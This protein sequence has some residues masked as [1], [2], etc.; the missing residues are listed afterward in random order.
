MRLYVQN[1]TGFGD[2]S[3]R[4]QLRV[5]DVAHEFLDHTDE[6]TWTVLS[7]PPVYCVFEPGDE[8]VPASSYSIP[9]MRTILK[10]EGRS[11]YTAVS[12]F[13]GCGGSSLGLK[14]AGLAVPW[15][16]EFVDIAADTYELNAPKAHVDRRDIRDVKGSDILDAVGLDVGQLDVLEGS[17]PCAAFSTAGRRTEG[18]GEERSYSETTQ[19]V[20]DLFEEY[21]RL[22]DEIRPRTFIAENVAG[23]AIGA[24]KGYLSQVVKSMRA[25]GYNVAVWDLDAQWLGVPQRRRRIIFAGSRTDLTGR[26]TPPTPHAR[27]IPLIEAIGDLAASES[28]V[29]LDPETGY[30]I[31]LGDFAIGTEWHKLQPGQSSERYFSL[32]RA[33]RALPAQTVTATAGIVAA[34]GVTHPT[35]CRKFT[36]TELR[37]IC[38]FPDDFE[39]IGS[40][41]QRWERLGRS[42]VPPMYR[43]VGKQLIEF[44][45]K[46]ET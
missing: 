27:R 19:R 7:Y 12:T 1:P 35:Q 25:L 13:S 39:L 26:L 4:Q 24:A 2:T 9:K 38:G 15:A 34:A 31:A 32:K 33:S 17:P 36:L 3:W 45:D 40:Y 8:P 6:P 21:V 37:R 16:S 42:V 20:D 29:E 46:Q 11:G 14:W 23:L 43:A 5:E 18:W 22:I 41:T 10:G 44:L 30:K 28:E